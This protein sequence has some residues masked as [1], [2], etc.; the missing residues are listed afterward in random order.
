MSAVGKLD[1][2]SIQQLWASPDGGPPPAGRDIH[3]V[4][5]MLGVPWH[6]GGAA[7][8]TFDDFTTMCHERNLEDLRL[9]LSQ[10]AD[11]HAYELI[12]RL[13]DQESLR[14]AAQKEF[15]KYT[16]E[17]LCEQTRLHTFSQRYST[18]K[19]AHEQLVAAGALQHFQPR[20]SYPPGYPFQDMVHDANYVSLRG[21]ELQA[22]YARLLG[23]ASAMQHGATK[24]ILGFDKLTL[25]A[26]YREAL[27]NDSRRRRSTEPVLLSQRMLEPRGSMASDDAEASSRERWGSASSRSSIVEAGD[28]DPVPPEPSDRLSNS[29]RAPSPPKH[30]RPAELRPMMVRQRAQIKQLDQSLAVKTRECEV[31]L[32]RTT[33]L[34]SQLRRSRAEGA[35]M[36]GDILCLVSH[37]D[38]CA[39]PEHPDTETATAVAAAAKGT[40][41]EIVDAV[42]LAVDGHRR[43]CSTNRALELE[44][45]EL[46]RRHEQGHEEQLAARHGEIICELE[47]HRSK[48]NAQEEEHVILR[49]KV[50]RKH[51]A[52]AELSELSQQLLE[53]LSAATSPERTDE[54]AKEI[55]GLQASLALA[56]HGRV[57]AETKLGKVARLAGVAASARVV[58]RRQQQAVIKTQQRGLA[59]AQS[60][61]AA[62][63]GEL[64]DTRLD[65]QLRVSERLW[66]RRAAACQ[67]RAALVRAPPA[68]SAGRAVDGLRLSAVQESRQS[69]AGQALATPTDSPAVTPLKEPEEVAAGGGGA[70]QWPKRGPKTAPKKLGTAARQLFLQDGSR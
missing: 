1:D 42:G 40:V 41:P 55:E 21:D 4:A 24:A 54:L 46:R 23:K 38:R 12:V 2:Q 33:E 39:S 13:Q 45:T 26:L 50:G 25:D 17:I 44:V 62:Q 11:R 53:E 16:F 30:V 20:L 10:H 43:L 28:P 68:R 58:E 14:D 34:E 36:H 65:A 22:Y 8:V 15:I 9:W 37:L 52:A 56:E 69:R 18:G 29:S 47:A 27:S 63:T 64:L 61:M 7:V 19:R 48:L 51:Q 60:E 31:L 32:A 70:A 35:R 57:A 67:L 59:A 3:E 6:G 66:S 5:A 49:E